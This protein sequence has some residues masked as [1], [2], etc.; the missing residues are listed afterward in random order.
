VNSTSHI[1]G[2]RSPLRIAVVGSGLAGLAATWLLGRHAD[3]TVYEAH[4]TPG[5]GAHSVRLGDGAGG[6]LIDVPLRVLTPAYYPTLLELYEEAGVAVAPVDYAASFSRLHD[7]SYFLYRN[8]HVGGRSLPWVSPSSLLQSET[9]SIARDV[10]RLHRQ[11]PVA[12]REGRLAGMTLQAYLEAEN[13]GR[14]FI[15]GFLLPAYASICTCSTQTV[16]DYPAE[17]IVDYFCSGVTTLGV[18]RAVGGSE[19]VVARLLAPATAVRTGTAVRA[20]TQDGDEVT[21]LDGDG[22]SARYDHVVLATPADRGAELLDPSDPLREALSRVPHE[23]SRVVVHRDPRLAPRD[24]SAWRPVNFIVAGE[25]PAPMATIWLNRVQPGL[26][27]A[28]DI[29]Q[30]WNPLV[31]PDPDLVIT[32]AMVSRPVVTLETHDLPETLAHLCQDSRRRIWPVGSYAA[33]G[34]PLLEAA[35]ASAARVADRLLRV[36]VVR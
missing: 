18:A 2:E 36:A 35:A 15:D 29:F 3:V 8:V 21:V 12:L 30:T 26:E 32:E 22:G 25:G 19:D 34:I 20:V 10:V 9:R 7:A 16:R 31:E 27:E 14:A 17:L 28:P 1:E 33:R 6:P 5:M 4:P 11:G 23:A 24:R 13:F